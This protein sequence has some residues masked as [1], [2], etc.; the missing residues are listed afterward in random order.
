[1]CKK[2]EGKSY[3]TPLSPFPLSDDFAFSKIGLDYAGPLFVKGIYE[4]YISLYTCASSH[5]IHLNLVPELSSK[6][7][8]RSFKRF[9]GRRGIPTEVLSDN[10]KTFKS[11]EVHDYIRSSRIKWIFNVEGAPWWGGFF[12]RLVKS[13][14]R[15][16]KEVV[17]YARLTDEELLTVLIEIEGVLNSRPLTYIYDDDLQPL[18]PSQLVIGRHLLTNPNSVIT[19]TEQIQDRGVITKQEKHLQKIF[20]HFWNRW[21]REY[22]TE[23]STTDKRTQREKQQNL[24]TLLACTKT[25]F[26]IIYGN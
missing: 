6:V 18:T 9:V 14:K 4:A 5:A 13:V 22:V 17:R 1:M 15:C 2:F 11:V 20:N 23:L 8:L 26:H 16:L 10:A 19:E 3:G 21:C 25:R 12:K 24:E 7:F